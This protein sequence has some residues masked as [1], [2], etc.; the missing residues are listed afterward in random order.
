MR[1]REIV[2]L[3]N[4][5]TLVEIKFDWIIRILDFKFSSGLSDKLNELNYS[6]SLYV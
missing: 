4:N 1:A 2:G 6:Y 3:R 5:F